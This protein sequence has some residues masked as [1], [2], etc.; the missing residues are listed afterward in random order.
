M[1]IHKQ[2][3]EL[4]TKVAI[5]FFISYV[6]LVLPFDLMLLGTP[7]KSWVYKTYYIR[8]KRLTRR[9]PFN[10]E[11]KQ[12]PFRVQRR[13]RR[14]RKQ[15]RYIRTAIRRSFLSAGVPASE[16]LNPFRFDISRRSVPRE[17]HFSPSDLPRSPSPRT[18]RV[19]V[20]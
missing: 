5:L 20:H 13:D 19:L 12:K 18:V 3:V 15:L 2:N 11:K 1:N 14:K 6:N 4:N 9:R 8:A 7:N 10:G 17:I 16:F